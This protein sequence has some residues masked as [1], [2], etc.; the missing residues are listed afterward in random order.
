[1]SARP[2]SAERVIVSVP[3]STP[4]TAS[5][6]LPG[7][8][9]GDSVFWWATSVI[10]PPDGNMA[11]YLASLEKLGRRDDRVYYP[12]H[13]PPVDAP[14]KLVRGTIAH[15]RL[16]EKQILKALEEG[17]MGVAEL[18]ARNYPGLDPRLAPAAAASVTAH[19]L[20]LDARERVRCS[21]GMWSL[22]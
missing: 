14:A 7:S 2:W 15:R 3:G 10:L 8:T 11:D 18:V 19:L 9:I 4:V 13:G 20:D 1:M 17:A 21:G 16:R 12:A 22:R 5:N 6:S